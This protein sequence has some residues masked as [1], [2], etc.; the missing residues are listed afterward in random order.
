MFAQAFLACLITS[1][2]AES[3]KAEVFD[4]GK[5]AFVKF[6]APWCGP[7]PREPGT[8]GWRC[9][10]NQWA[11]QAGE[12]KMFTPQLDCTRRVGDSQLRRDLDPRVHFYKFKINCDINQIVSVWLVLLV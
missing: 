1:L 12:A 4:S 8:H 2:G 11:Q 6:F 3:F 10:P 5:N 9:S 7:E